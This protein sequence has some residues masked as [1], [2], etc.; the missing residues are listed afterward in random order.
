MRNI[1]AENKAAFG[2]VRKCVCGKLIESW[3]EGWQEATQVI[4]D[5]N[6]R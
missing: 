2:W 6:I 1:I 5:Y 3:L 4:Y